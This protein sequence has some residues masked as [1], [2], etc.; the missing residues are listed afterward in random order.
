MDPRPDQIVFFLLVVTG[1]CYPHLATSLLQGLFDRVRWGSS[2]TATRRGMHW[3]VPVINKLEIWS[4]F[5]W[6]WGISEY[7]SFSRSFS[8]WWHVMLVDCTWS[9]IHSSTMQIQMTLGLM[10]LLEEAPSM[11]IHHQRFRFN[12]FHRE[13][14]A[15]NTF[16]HGLGD[17]DTFHDTSPKANTHGQKT[18]VLVK[19]DFLGVNVCKCCGYADDA[20]T[21][22]SL[23][24]LSSRRDTR[25]CLTITCIYIYICWLQQNARIQNSFMICAIVRSDAAS[26]LISSRWIG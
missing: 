9:E 24:F 21:C 23:I 19:Q 8:R 25:K 6:V 4:R 13:K 18:K 11:L 2:E 26:I 3:C 5:L 1:D 7:L 12:A 10:F 22:V 14:N 16:P 17:D 15:R 20:V